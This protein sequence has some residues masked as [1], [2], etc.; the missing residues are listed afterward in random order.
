MVFSFDS[1]TF[2]AYIRS[3]DTVTPNIVYMAG[4]TGDMFTIYFGEAGKNMHC[5]GK[6]HS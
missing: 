4:K 5:R 1:T 3:E 6:E 2:H